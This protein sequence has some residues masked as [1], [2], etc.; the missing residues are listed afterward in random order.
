MVSPT[1]STRKSLASQPKG[2]SITTAISSVPKSAKASRA[3][4]AGVA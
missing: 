2:S 4:A 3:E 1:A